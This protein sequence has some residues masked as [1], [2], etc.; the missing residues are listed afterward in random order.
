MKNN[1]FLFT[2][3]QILLKKMPFVRSIV[4]LGLSILFITEL[5]AAQ[6]RRCPPNEEWSYPID[7]CNTCLPLL[8]CRVRQE[9]GCNCRTGYTRGIVSEICIPRRFCPLAPT[10]TTSTTSSTPT[11]EPTSTTMEPRTE[12]TSTTMEPT[13][14]STSTTMEPRTESTSTTM[15]PRTESTNTTMEPT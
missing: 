2:P 15:E 1:L 4:S 14:E 3:D 13:T 11:M 7:G 8:W 6:E 5:V 12:S 9:Y 10:P